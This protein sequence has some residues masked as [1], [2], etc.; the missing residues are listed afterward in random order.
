[1]LDSFA[2][3]YRNL[4]PNS[5]WLPNQ[6]HFTHFRVFTP[7]PRK[8]QHILH[9]PRDVR[10]MLS[11]T[12]PMHA[13][14][15]T[16]YFLQPDKL[17]KRGN[18]GAI[19]LYSDE[20]VIDIDREELQEAKES[21]LKI[22]EVLKFLQIPIRYIVYSGRKGFHIHCSM[23]KTSHSEMETISIKKAMIS[24]IYS[25]SEILFRE[26]IAIDEPVSWDT[27]RLI[28]IPGSIHGKTGNL[29]EVIREDEIKNYTPKKVID[30]SNFI[31][32]HGNSR[33]IERQVLGVA[34]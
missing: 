14:Y 29:V 19:F 16:S 31:K 15:V 9:T 20:F 4:N 32:L 23:E 25:S 7:T 22:L 28:R 33:D 3:Y 12:S 18:D 27:R 8:I 10:D 24:R 21:T 34:L 13:F 6:I 17:G 5:I 1:M 11:A 26:R 2:E 30:V